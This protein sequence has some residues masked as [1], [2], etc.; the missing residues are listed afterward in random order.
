M[1][2]NISFSVTY[3]KDLDYKDPS[4]VGLFGT[5]NFY[6]KVKDE[7]EFEGKH[8]EDFRIGLWH[9]LPRSVAKRFSK[10]LIIDE[11]FNEDLNNTTGTTD[12][13]VEIPSEIL[14]KYEGATIT[15][16]LQ[17]QF[18]ENLLTIPD[19]VIVL[20]FHG[21]TASRGSGHRVD[22]Y[23]V[24][25]NLNYHVITFDY[26]S[27]GDSDKIPPSE[28]G[29]VNDGFT[30]FK[31]IRSITKNPIIFWGHSLGTGVSSHLLANMEKLG[32]PNGAKGL[33][34]EAPFTNIKDEIREHP[35][36]KVTHFYS[37]NFIR[38]SMS[39]FFVFSLQP[40]K[41]LPWFD[42]TISNPMHCN[43]LRFE[44]DKYISQYRQ[45]VLIM[46]AEDDYVIPFHLGY[47]LYR[48][49]LDDRNKTWGPVEFKRFDDSFHYGHKYICRSPELPALISKFVG[50][51]KNERD[52]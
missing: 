15:E 1:K 25:R 50:T 14:E 18:Y 13:E 30:V 11:K 27:Y 39:V 9:V 45:P 24:L 22:M 51:Y 23:K 26:R 29:L 33:I 35:F 42:V 21:N 28:D 36:A 19:T 32:I 4:S 31:Y 2:I 7:D 20:Y 16:S 5:R 49:A 41:N 52:F 47:K 3:P 8:H 34:L 12:Q 38:I 46:H 17:Q 6:L 10:E 44:S 40:F 37:Q 43:Y 48:I